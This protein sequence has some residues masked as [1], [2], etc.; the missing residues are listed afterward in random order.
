MRIPD[1][2]IP[3][4][5]RKVLL[6]IAGVMWLCVG[7]MLLNYS[8]SWLVLESR[9]IIIIFSG[10]GIF[11]ALLVHHFGFLKVADKNLKRILLL[12]EKVSVFSFITWKSY[13]LIAGMITMGV[14]LRHSAI[15]K[16]Y[17]AVLYIGI[18]FALTLSSIRYL[19][20]FIKELIKSKN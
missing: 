20:F 3:A 6:F 2:F 17:L 10:I 8:Y 13:I 11:L 18:G 9:R 15:P 1:R 7:T 5:T 12:E 4:V 16:H 19:R 14:T